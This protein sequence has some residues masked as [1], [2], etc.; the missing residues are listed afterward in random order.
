MHE[1]TGPLHLTSRRLLSTEE[2]TDGGAE[3][4]GGGILLPYRGVCVCVMSW[5]RE[6]TGTCLEDK[7]SL[8]RVVG[9]GLI[10]GLVM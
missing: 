6:H 3:E 4:R 5:E 10:G 7:Q 8:T 1:H 2:P 9:C